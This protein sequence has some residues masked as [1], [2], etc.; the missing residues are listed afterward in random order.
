M[1]TGLLYG[2]GRDIEGLE[3]V[4]R[5]QLCPHDVKHLESVI[6]RT[7]TNLSATNE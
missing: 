1:Q 6:K 2:V 4:V 3:R 5:I 7:P